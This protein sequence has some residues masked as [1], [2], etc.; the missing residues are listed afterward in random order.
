MATGLPEPKFEN[1][2]GGFMVTLFADRW[3]DENIKKMGL[4]EKETK[5]VMY[6]KEKG[7]INNNSYQQL[8]GVSRRTSSRDLSGLVEKNI[9]EQVGTTGKGTEYILTRH[10]RAKR[11]TKTP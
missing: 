10:K 11:A 3:N 5:A 8:T 1:N 4:T 6:V 9:F 7:T 2:S